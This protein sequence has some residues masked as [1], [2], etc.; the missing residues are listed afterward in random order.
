LHELAQVLP[1]VLARARL[2]PVLEVKEDQIVFADSG[3]IEERRVLDSDYIES[4]VL[5]QCG[6]E[7]RRCLSPMV[8]RIIHTRDE[9][10]AGLLRRWGSRVGSGGAEAGAEG[11]GQQRE[12][13]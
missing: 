5:G 9:Q 1:R 6:G 4:R 13:S 3:R 7:H 8:A 10:D 11:K 12:E 2:L